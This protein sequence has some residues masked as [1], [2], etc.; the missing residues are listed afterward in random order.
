MRN[1]GS[2]LCLDTLG[3]NENSWINL[4]VYFCQ[5]GVSANQVFSLSYTNELRREESCALVQGN[6]GRLGHCSGGAEQ[7]WT[8]TKESKTIV[9]TKTGL[10]LDV[11]GVKNGETAKLNECAPNTPGQIWEFKNY[12]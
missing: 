2:S 9:H 11:T 10:C 4:G 1:P 3:K 5:G 12:S 7:K 6:E 8:H